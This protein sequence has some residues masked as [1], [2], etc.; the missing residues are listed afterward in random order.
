MNSRS[1]YLTRNGWREVRPGQWVK[2]PITKLYT[3]KDA[4]QIARR[5]EK[6][7]E[8]ENPK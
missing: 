5:T 2:P 7:M 3:E 4:H 6:E 1:E 8:K